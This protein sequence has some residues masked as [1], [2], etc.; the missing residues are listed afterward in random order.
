[1]VKVTNVIAC[2]PNKSNPVNLLTKN[3]DTDYKATL[4]LYILECD[5]GQVNGRT[6]VMGALHSM[7]MDL[8][9]IL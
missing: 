4:L 6:Y 2:I 8:I 7:V 9:V 5:L 3:A 1:M